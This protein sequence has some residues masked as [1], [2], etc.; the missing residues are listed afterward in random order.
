MYSKNFK[1][2]KSRNREIVYG[3]N[4]VEQVLVSSPETILSAWYVSGRETDERIAKIIATLKQYGVV[5]QNS[6]RATVET[7]AEGGV[8]QGIVFEIKP[9]P[10]LNEHDLQ[11]KLD[12]LKEEGVEPFLLILD[13]VTDPRNLGAAM[14]SVWAAGAHAVIVP[15]DKSAQ[16]SPA[17]RKAASGA[18]SAVPLYVVTN[19]ARVLD[20][21]DD[22]E[23]KIVGMDGEAENDI[24]STDFTGP[25]AIVM[26][27]EES[28]M[29]RLTRE[30]CT[31]ITKI[32]MA[33]G[34]ESLN[35]SVA[36]GIALFEAVRQRG[37]TK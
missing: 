35:V 15:K 31:A 37:L 33:H 20:D 22:R 3:I 11:D 34:V 14:R 17:A 4:A 16:F 36:A 21:L 9:M 6:R 10:L 19:L 24:Y 27:S 25:L 7:M 8:H 29:R 32:P 30:K 12:S 18:A 5:A 23:F 13:N 1:N 2:N 28:G 26:G